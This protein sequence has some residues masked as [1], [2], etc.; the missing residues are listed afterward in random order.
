MGGFISPSNVQHASYYGIG[1]QHV[2]LTKW[3]EEWMGK[4][5]EFIYLR[6]NN[7]P[8]SQKQNLAI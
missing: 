3:M 7:L 1:T 6:L 8:F 5:L 4:N 2:S